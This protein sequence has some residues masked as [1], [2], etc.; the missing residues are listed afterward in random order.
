MKAETDTRCLK[1]TGGVV[2]GGM[3]FSMTPSRPASRG[4]MPLDIGRTVAIWGRWFGVL[5]VAMILPP[6]AGRVW[7]RLPVPS[8]ISSSVQSAVRPV[9]MRAA[10]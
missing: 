10:T 6:M 2:C 8:S 1:K 5:M 9:T 7:S 3:L 4:G